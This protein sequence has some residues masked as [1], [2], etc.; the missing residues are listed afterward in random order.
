MPS[1]DQDSNTVTAVFG[2]PGYTLKGIEKEMSKHHLTELKSEIMLIR[3]RQSIDDFRR[4]TPEEREAV[5]T[6]WKSR[7]DV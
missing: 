2:I 7:S 4:A 3:L 1:T 5:V 6:R